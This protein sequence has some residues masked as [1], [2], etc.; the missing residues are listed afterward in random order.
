[1]TRHVSD[2]AG[3]FSMIEV[4]IASV[5]LS[6]MI[7][8]TSSLALSGND[9]QEFARR[10]NRSTEISQ[11][12]LDEM[13]LELV[14]CVRVFG[15]DAEGTGNLALLDLSDAPVPLA[16]Q[17]LPTISA[18]GTIEADT[19]TRQITGNSLFF[20]KLAWSD[21]FVCTSGNE[22]LV[23]VYRWVHYYMTPEEGGPRADSPIGLN[24]VRIVSEP[25]V[26]GASV[27]RITD[28]VDQAEVLVHLATGT[29]DTF[30]T[31]HP[32]C[33]VVWLRA[34]APSAVGTFR[35]IDDVDGSLSDDP[36]GGRPDPWQILRRDT[37]VQGLLSYRHHSVA[38]NYSRSNFGVGRF[39][40][41]S[42]SGAG[43]PHGFEV[44]VVGPSSAR[45]VMLHLVVASTNRRGHV[46]WSDLQMIVDARD[47]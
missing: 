27:D 45:Q 6:T 25:L 10:L 39:G 5:L 24:L 33:Q 46:A 36:F 3:G 12:L 42:N 9:A 1:M 29:A 34:G 14:S 2:P 20:A 38:T 41:V 16:G 7:L 17:L 13:R 11:D 8:I 43:F 44:Q 30:G 4:V 23:D 19:A 32:L 22:Y 31:T 35:Q 28:P 26:D 21:R 40:L 15:N 47:L 18:N 37:A